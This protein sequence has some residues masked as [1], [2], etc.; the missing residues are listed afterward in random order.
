M[1]LQDVVAAI[2]VGHME[3][4]TQRSKGDTLSY[5]TMLDLNWRID[6]MSSSNDIKSMAQ[7][8][9]LV[10]L[11]LQKNAEKQGEMPGTQSVVLEMNKDTLQTMIDGMGKI[12]SQLSSIQ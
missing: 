6:V 4:W 3:E 11:L 1:E 2:L 10:E 12:A 8:T 9:A 7:P 5:P